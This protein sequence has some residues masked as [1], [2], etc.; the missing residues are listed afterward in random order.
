ML[1]SCDF[2]PKDFFFQ[3]DIKEESDP[4]F[5]FCSFEDFIAIPEL[6]IF[7]YFVCWLLRYVV[8]WIDI[9][10]YF[11]NHFLINVILCVDSHML[12]KCVNKTPQKGDLS[13]KDRNINDWNKERRDCNSRIFWAR[14]W[15]RG[16]GSKEWGY[17]SLGE[18]NLLIIFLF[19]IWVQLKIA[20]L[21]AVFGCIITIMTVPAMLQRTTTT[22][23]TTTTEFLSSETM[24]TTSTST[25][26]CDNYNFTTITKSITTTHAATSTAIQIITNPC[27]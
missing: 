25:I 18:V 10:K 9:F 11:V 13:Q 24:T 4:V 19:K 23:T 5:D 15:R 21:V 14:Q 1:R 26:D 20:G 2:L 17:L 3:I 6:P 27:F 7:D 12:I 16:N 8:F 22:S